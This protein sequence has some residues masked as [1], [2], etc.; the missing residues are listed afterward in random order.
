MINFKFLN[1]LWAFRAHAR[2]PVDLRTLI[3][4]QILIWWSLWLRIFLNPGC[5]SVIGTS[6]YVNVQ[7]K[8]ISWHLWLNGLAHLMTV[9]QSFV[10][11]TQ[12][13]GFHFVFGQCIFIDLLEGF[14]SVIFPGGV[15]PLLFV[16]EILVWCALPVHTP[17]GTPTASLEEIVVWC[18]PPDS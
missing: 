4:L 7:S 12:I 10:L 15:L 18:A 1:L 8:L 2:P 3:L 9:T 6:K 5:S 13:Q 17:Q 14:K 16:E 11:T